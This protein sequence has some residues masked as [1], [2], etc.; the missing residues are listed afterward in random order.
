MIEVDLRISSR[1][2]QRVHST[3]S[4][5]LNQSILHN[6]QYALVWDSLRPHASNEGG[7]IDLSSDADVATEWV[8]F[9]KVRKIAKNFSFLLVVEPDET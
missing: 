5:V 1:M 7:T 8:S 9:S 4:Y 3:F 6:L 2:D